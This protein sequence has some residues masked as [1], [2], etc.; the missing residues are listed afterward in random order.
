MRLYI[1]ERREVRGVAFGDSA[2]AWKWLKLGIKA[3]KLSSL[4]CW[5]LSTIFSS[6]RFFVSECTNPTFYLS[7]FLYLPLLLRAHIFKS[8][9]KKYSYKYIHIYACTYVYLCMYAQNHQKGHAYIRLQKFQQ[10]ALI[11]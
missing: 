7:L 6:S 3:W 11:N 10:N 4:W 8:W 5:Y 1:K 2:W 9:L